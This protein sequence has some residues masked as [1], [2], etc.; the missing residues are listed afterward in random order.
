[1]IGTSQIEIY[2]MKKDDKDDAFSIQ[3][4]RVSDF[5]IVKHFKLSEYT[6]VWILIGILVCGLSV[7]CCSVKREY[8]KKNGRIDDDDENYNKMD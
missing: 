8:T 2:Y 6:F 4:S 7:L 5:T 1:M 3:F